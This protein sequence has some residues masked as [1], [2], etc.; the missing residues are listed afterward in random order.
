LADLAISEI[1][2]ANEVL[3]GG[4]LHRTAQ[5]DFV[6]ARRNV[7]MAAD[8]TTS[9]Q[10]ISEANQALGFLTSARNDIIAP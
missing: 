2:D 8:A 4:G 9:S 7:R 5:K 6:R 1:D 3:V 10:K